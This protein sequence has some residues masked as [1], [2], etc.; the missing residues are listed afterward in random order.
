MMIRFESDILQHR[1]EGVWNWTG[2]DWMESRSV[3]IKLESLEWGWNSVAGVVDVDM[4]ETGHGDD[5]NRLRM[6]KDL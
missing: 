1:I 5:M 6:N 3:L 4:S 2:L